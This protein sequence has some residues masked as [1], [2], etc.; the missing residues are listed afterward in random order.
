MFRTMLNGAVLAESGRTVKVE[1]NRYFPRESLH[2][3][4][5]TAGAGRGQ[6]PT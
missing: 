6:A 4:A 5:G 1:G 3:E 2:R